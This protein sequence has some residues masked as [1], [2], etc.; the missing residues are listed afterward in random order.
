MDLDAQLALAAASV[1]IAER[2]P[3]ADAI[4]LATAQRHDATVWTLDAD[5][6][7]K[8][9]VRYFRRLGG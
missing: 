1:S 4:I 2:L 6:E 9:G 7:G 8:P 5:F 3:M